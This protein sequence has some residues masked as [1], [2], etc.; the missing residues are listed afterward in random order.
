M[1]LRFHTQTA[2]STLQGE[3]V[4]VNV[5]RTTV[6]AL[7]ALLGGTQ[8][9]HTNGRDEALSLPTE[10]SA[11]LALRTQQILAHES[12]T[13][14]NADPL[15]GSY[16][17][18]YLTDELEKKIMSL[19]DRIEDIGGSVRCI[20]TGYFRD[21]IARSAYKHQKAVE[22]GKSIVVGVNEYTSERIEAPGILKL[23]PE[24]ERGQVAA[25]RKRRKARDVKTVEDSLQRLKEAA[26]SGA[27]IVNP[28]IEAVEN[29]VT[30]GE[31]SDIFREVW[32]EYQESG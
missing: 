27:D 3:Q 14:A 21:E 17:V 29:Y 19:M 31:I 13:A 23:D 12:G 24:L 28:V 6:Q 10:A 1:L 22:Q 2:G 4:D 11:R 25:L 30:V 32:G 20:K 7:A 16:Y 9:L 26:Q 5:V 15:G 18:E 8:S